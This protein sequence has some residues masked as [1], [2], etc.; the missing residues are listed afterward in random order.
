MAVRQAIT[1]LLLEFSAHHITE[2]GEL[3]T[4][5]MQSGLLPITG[6]NQLTD[7]RGLMMILSLHL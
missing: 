2:S 6:S 1:T 7:G 3:L 5:E 4:V